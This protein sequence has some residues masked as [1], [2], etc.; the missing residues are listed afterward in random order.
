M[1][2]DAL[3]ACVLALVDPALNA[4]EMDLS[5]SAVVVILLTAASCSLV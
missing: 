3:H 4:E 1:K 5:C 2:H